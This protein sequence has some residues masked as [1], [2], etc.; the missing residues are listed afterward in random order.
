LKNEKYFIENQRC[1]VVVKYTLDTL[2]QRWFSVQLYNLP[3]LT[4]KR[5]MWR[6]TWV[7]GKK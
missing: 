1:V 4:M 5:V 7:A 6:W 3:K 2:D